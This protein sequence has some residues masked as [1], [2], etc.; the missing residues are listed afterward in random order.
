MGVGVGVLFASP[1]RF[2]NSI[3]PG[4]YTYRDVG[5]GCVCCEYWHQEKRLIESRIHRGE[6]VKLMRPTSLFFLVLC[7]FVITSCGGKEPDP[8]KDFEGIISR[9]DSYLSEQPLLLLVDRTVKVDGRITP[10][11]KVDKIVGYEMVYDIQRT[12]SL[13]SPYLGYEDILVIELAYRRVSNQDS[14]DLISDFY[15]RELEKTEREMRETESSDVKSLLEQNYQILKDRRSGFYSADDALS[16]T[17]PED[18]GKEYENTATIHYAYQE[19][20]WVY[21]SIEG[22]AMP[23]WVISCLKELPQNQEWRDAIGIGR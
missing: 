8:K 14:G 3:L 21:K 10:A 11:Y 4:H 7:I 22:S 9:L 18:F 19:G 23:G 15:K 1:F 13:V 20:R 5:R 16:Y 6:I 2:N 12:D 17:E